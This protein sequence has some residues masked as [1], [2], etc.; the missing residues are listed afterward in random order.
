[1][2][3]SIKVTLQEASPASVT[4]RIDAVVVDGTIRGVRAYAFADELR[5]KNIAFVIATAGD[6]Y[7]PRGITVPELRDAVFVEKPLSEAQLIEAVA[8][9]LDRRTPTN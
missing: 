1:M 4:S 2:P 8:A 9:V 3:A 7:R 5:R 6:W